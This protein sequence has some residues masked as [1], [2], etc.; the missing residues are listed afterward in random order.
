MISVM[1][2]AATACERRGW[3][4]TNL[5]LQKLLYLA[6]MRYVGR[7][8]GER[9]IRENFE[10]WKY[11]PVV[12]RLYEN[13]KKFGATPIANIFTVERNLVL[14][15]HQEIR[16]CVDEFRNKTPGQLVDMTHRPWGA[17]AAFYRPGV[18]H[19]EIPDDAIRDEYNAQ[20]F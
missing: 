8:G 9:L 6:N 14:P 12:A 4:L 3:R 1:S 20:P 2:A 11:G 15:E 16:W 13:V 10:A 5:E 17:W 7:H 19:I 18:D